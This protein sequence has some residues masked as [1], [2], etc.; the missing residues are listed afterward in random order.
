M[1]WLDDCGVSDLCESGCGVLETIDRDGPRVWDP[2]LVRLCQSALL[3]VGHVK[4]CFGGQRKCNS[5]AFEARAPGSESGDRS[6]HRWNKHTSSMRANEIEQGLGVGNG[7]DVIAGKD[8]LA[9]RPTRGE[10]RH[11][12]TV[13]GTSR[14]IPLS[15]PAAPSGPVLGW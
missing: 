10:S 12:R 1:G 5:L 6:V 14:K 15:S 11:V 4:C 7:I 2:E 8:V 3:V 13:D 9:L